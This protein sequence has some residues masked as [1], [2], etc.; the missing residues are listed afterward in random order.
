MAKLLI[1]LAFYFL[2]LTESISSFLFYCHSLSQNLH[3]PSSGVL[4]M[5]SPLV[6]LHALKE[7]VIFLKC[8][9]DHRDLLYIFPWPWKALSCPNDP[10]VLSPRWFV[11]LEP[12][13]VSENI[14]THHSRM[15]YWTLVTKP[16]DILQSTGMSLT[17]KNY[18]APNVSAVVGIPG[19]RPWRP[20]TLIWDHLPWLMLQACWMSFGFTDVQSYLLF[21]VFCI[22]LLWRICFLPYNSSYSSSKSPFPRESLP[23]AHRPPMY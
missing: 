6:S 16:L 7:R 1:L 12:F 9:S 17:T 3:H 22:C 19:L 23:N 4:A 14:F 2:I 20:L 10:V 21:L 15:Y 5:A 18:P 8:K 13:S 11:P